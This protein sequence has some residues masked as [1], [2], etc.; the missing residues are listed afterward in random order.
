MNSHQLIS[1]CWLLQFCNDTNN[2]IVTQLE[3]KG[4][5]SLNFCVLEKKFLSSPIHPVSILKSKQTQHNFRIFQVFFFLCAKIVSVFSQGKLYIGTDV[6]LQGK[7]NSSRN[8]Y[9]KHQTW[10]N[11]HDMKEYWMTFCFPFFCFSLDWH[12]LNLV[13]LW[14]SFNY[15][16]D[17]SAVKWSAMCCR[18]NW[19]EQNIW[20]LSCWF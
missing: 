4:K 10:P 19:A 9:W 2:F 18:W 7:P 11:R 14:Q 15:S 20:K 17:K 3:H 6:S 12:K 1:F 13:K 8:F 5:V 16:C